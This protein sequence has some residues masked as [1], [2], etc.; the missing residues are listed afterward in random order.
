MDGQ[1]AWG[2]GVH[3]LAVQDEIATFRQVSGNHRVSG[4]G[5][6]KIE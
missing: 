4:R 1:L 5:G 6:Q 3:G 2:L